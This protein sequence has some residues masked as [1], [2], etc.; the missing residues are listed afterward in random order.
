MTDE[1]TTPARA[2]RFSLS[3][4]TQLALAAG[5]WTAV[6]IGL[7]AMGLVWCIHTWGLL[8]LAY[9]APFLAVS[10][11]KSKILDRVSIGTVGHIRQRDPNG[12][13]LGFLPL[14]S[15]ILIGGMMGTGILLR[16]TLFREPG[17]WPRGYLGFLYV[18]VGV[19]LLLSS[20]KLWD[21]WRAQTD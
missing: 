1:T 11:L 19:A 10:L 5:M 15:W 20:R 2:G 6:G 4:K 18:A 14:K 16:S 3:R 9:A 17:G 12:F 8:G 21:A 7:P 13:I